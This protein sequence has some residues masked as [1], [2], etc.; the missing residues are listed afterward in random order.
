MLTDGQVGQRFGDQLQLSADA[1]F[2]AAE[3]HS[4]CCG[5]GKFIAEGE[6]AA[7]ICGDLRVRTNAQAPLR[8]C[9]SQ[10]CTDGIGVGLG[11]TMD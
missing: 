4:C 1:F 5:V 10:K 3:L 8:R 7:R 11:E 6:Q 9:R 2:V